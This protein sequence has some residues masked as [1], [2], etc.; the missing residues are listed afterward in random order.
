VADDVVGEILAMIAAEAGTVVC[1]ATRGRSAL[2]E[3]VLGSMTHDIVVASPTPVVVIGPHAALPE[4]LD[5]V[6]VAFDGS[7]TSARAL[8][9]AT[10]WAAQL[11]A[12]AWLTQVLEPNRP[13][14]DEVPLMSVVEGSLLRRGAGIMAAAGVHAEWDVLHGHHPAETLAR[15]ASAHGVAL[16]VVGSHGKSGTQRLLLGSV[17]GRLAHDAPCPLLVVG[18]SYAEPPSRK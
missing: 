7:D 3:L 2:G 16:L 10:D 14:L 11:R 8:A 5:T 18:P 15:W 17:T 12:T 13:E 1:M 4:R 9:A 6:Q